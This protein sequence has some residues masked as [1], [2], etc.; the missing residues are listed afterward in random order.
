MASIRI[1]R[2]GY[3]GQNG[4]VDM[5]IPIEEERWGLYGPET[6]RW[7]R[8][9]IMAALPVLFLTNGG[10]AWYMSPGE[11]VSPVPQVQFVQPQQPGQAPTVLVPAPVAPVVL[12]APVATTQPSAVQLVQ[13][14]VIQP[15]V[16]Q[17]V[18]VQPVVLQQTQPPAPVARERREELELLASSPLV[19]VLELPERPK[20]IW[21]SPRNK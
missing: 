8:R 1:N 10:T 9:I 4:A 14:A 11:K 6:V 15:M 13:P 21:D 5:A 16:I 2:V 7:A 3:V 19:P 12:P 17:P 18:V 20:S